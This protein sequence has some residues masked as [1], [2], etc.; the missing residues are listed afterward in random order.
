MWN[1]LTTTFSKESILALKYASIIAQSMN[2]R[3]IDADA[4]FLWMWKLIYDNDGYNLFCDIFDISPQSIPFLLKK[5]QYLFDHIGANNL[6]EVTILDINTELHT[7][8][9]QQ[10]QSKKGEPIDMLSLFLLSFSYLSSDLRKHISHTDIDSKT[11][12]TQLIKLTRNPL[13]SQEWLFA[14]LQTIHTILDELDLDINEVDVMDIKNLDELHGML[15]AMESEIIEK[16]RDDKGDVKKK[17]KDEESK[18]TVDYFWTN[19]T[20]ECK[21]GFIDPIIGRAKEIDQVIYTLLRKTKNNPLLVGEAGVGKTAVVE[22]LAQRIVANEVPDKLKYKKIYLLDMGTL[23][24]GTKYRGEFEARMKAILEEAMDEHNNI[25]LFIDELHTI[26]GAGGQDNNDAAQMIKPLL[27]RGKIKL[28][29]ATTFDEYQKHI[30]KDAALKRR[31]QE[32]VIN[33]PSE[34]DTKE[35]LLG[36]KKVYEDFHG[37]QIDENSIESA[38]NLSQRYMLNRHLPDKAFDIIDEASAR[39]STMETKLDNDKEYQATEKEIDILEKKIQRAIESQDY[40]LAANL[41]EE[42]Q[43][44]KE[45]LANIRSNKNIPLHLRPLISAEDIGNVVSEKVG[46]PTHVINESEVEKLKS[47]DTLLKSHILGQY[48]AVDAVVKVITRNRLSIIEKEKPI[49]SFLFLGPTGV[50]KT[51]LAKLIAKSYFG[52]KKALVR[53]DMSEYMEKHSVSKLIGSPAG[54]VGYDEGG[55]LT[56]AIR[57]RPYSVVLFDEIEKAAPD[58]LNILLQILDEGRLK[59][60][61]GRWVDFKNTVIIMTSNIGSEEFAKKQASIGFN[62]QWSTGDINKDFD[63]IKDKVLEEV[64]EFMTPE[65]LNRIDHKIVF[66]PLSKTTMVKIFKKDLKDFICQW[67]QDKTVSLPKFTEKKMKSIIDEIY[68]P[69]YWARPIS[70][71]I[72]DQIESDIIK[73]ILE[74]EG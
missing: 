51:Y 15:D 39:K 30:E 10:I 52:D 25:I 1:K 11:L 54:Y 36:L 45:E 48:D 27:A 38:I 35:I 29:G 56:E 23:L 18:L 63:T 44:L 28:I 41:K 65:L 67:K 72:H 40:F 59:D 4:L 47:L 46:I 49:G 14:F 42:E 70:R 69:Q 16:P 50:G 57:R 17:N 8:L 43:K 32:V 58:V 74:R 37:V 26:I 64:K 61:K 19:L 66:K 6:Q 3:V 33:E 13:L 2:K 60:S 20:K 68:D 73:Q 62:V 55:Q 24:A 5:Y 34:W 21:N 12:Y 9:W 53:M 22:G 71:Y 31:F 7:Q